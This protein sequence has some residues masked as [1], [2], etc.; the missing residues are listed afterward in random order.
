MTVINPPVWLNSATASY[1]ADDDRR[2]IEAL[3]GG[4]TGIL[5]SG[6]LAPTQRPTPDMQVRIAGGRAFIRNSLDA[7]AGVYMVDNQGITDLSIDASTSNP[8]YDRIIAEVRDQQYSGSSNDWR[9][10]VVKGTAA[11]TPSEPSLAAFSNYI[12]L[13]RVTV[14]ANVTTIT[15]ADILDRRLS[16]SKGRAAALGGTVVTTSGNLPTDS[17]TEGLS[18][19]TTDDNQ[20]LIHNGSAWVSRGAYSTIPP[21]YYAFGPFSRDLNT[22]YGDALSVASAVVAPYPLTMHIEVSGNTGFGA[23]ATNR[24]AMRITDFGVTVVVGVGNFL[25]GPVVSDMAIDTA[26]AMVVGYHMIGK[27]DFAAGATCAFK[28]QFACT[29]GVNAYVSGAAKLTF[30]PKVS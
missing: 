23:G 29:G 20:D 21:Q 28:F 13:A 7:N 25:S 16:S 4:R 12:E 1:T 26:S 2:L 18:A 8:R 3:I 5:F 24:T 9:L 30:T 11:P 14:G 17:L 19:L 10:H 6:D 22:G 15:N 27:I